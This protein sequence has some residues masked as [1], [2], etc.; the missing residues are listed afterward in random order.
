M[1][2]L[3]REG[4]IDEGWSTTRRQVSP[5]IR[6]C[7]QATTMTGIRTGAASVAPAQSMIVDGLLVKQLKEKLCINGDDQP[8]DEQ[9]YRQVTLDAASF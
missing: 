8:G 6:R 9:C 5:E 2:P 3:S 4:I 1:L 7:Q